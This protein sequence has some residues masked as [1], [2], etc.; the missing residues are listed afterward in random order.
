MKKSIVILLTWRNFI[1]NEETFIHSEYYTRINSLI[2]NEELIQKAKEKGYEIVLKMHPNAAEYIDLFEKNDYVKFDTVTRYHDII[3]DSALMI[4][5]YSSVVYDFAYLE[6]PIIYYHY[7][8][9]HHFDL[10]TSYI[11][12]ETS[13]FGDVVKNEE[14]LINKIIYYIDNDCLMED[15]YKDNVH[16]FFKYND[17][18]NSKRVYDWILK[19]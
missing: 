13:G 4:S 8:D 2:N 17:K 9:D 10:D 5:D 16:K 11:D 15:K 12:L 6:K 3:C 18:N 1:N 19:H 14:D 7:G